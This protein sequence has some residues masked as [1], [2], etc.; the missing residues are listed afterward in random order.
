MYS[1]GAIL[2]DIADPT[3][4]IGRLNEPLLAVTDTEREGYVPNVVYSCGS[5]I[6]GDDLLLPHGLTD[7]TSRIARVP[8]KALLARLVG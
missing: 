8:V 5:M 2:L 1:L 7:T 4:L 3:R 6:H